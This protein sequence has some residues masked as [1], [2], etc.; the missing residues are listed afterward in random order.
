LANS[1]IAD[2]QEP[3]DVDSLRQGVPQKQHRNENMF[4][5]PGD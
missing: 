4:D 2:N 5:R 3:Q 1:G